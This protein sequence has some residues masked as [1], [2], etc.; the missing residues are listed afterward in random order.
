ML[1]GKIKQ[2]ECKILFGHRRYPCAPPGSQTLLP[3]HL[4]DLH[5]LLQVPKATYSETQ[6]ILALVYTLPLRYQVKE[7]NVPD[8]KALGFES[9]SGSSPSSD[10]NYCVSLDKS[11]SFLRF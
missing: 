8:G 11:L 3:S 2:L 7:G 4:S 5:F 9:G 10:T 6:K 1:L